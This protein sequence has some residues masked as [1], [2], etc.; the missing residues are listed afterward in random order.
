[1][2][3]KP[4]IV[5]HRFSLN[6]NISVVVRRDGT[7]DGIGMDGFDGFVNG[8]WNTGNEMVTWLEGDPDSDREA[9][10]RAE[11][12]VYAIHPCIRDHYAEFAK[13]A[14]LVGTSE[15]E[16][17]WYWLFMLREDIELQMETHYLPVARKLPQRRRM[18]LYQT[19]LRQCQK[20]ED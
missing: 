17:V 13:D 12:M 6:N 14:D 3:A 16:A 5:A 10:L 20:G 8:I 11:I 18:L 15:D 2:K 7:D 19:V 4:V 1:M 9:M